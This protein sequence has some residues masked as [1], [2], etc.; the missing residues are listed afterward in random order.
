[1]LVF[2]VLYF[3]KLRGVARKFLRFVEAKICNISVDSIFSGTILAVATQSVRKISVAALFPELTLPFSAPSKDFIFLC[4]KEG[5]RKR[6][7]EKKRF[8]IITAK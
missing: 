2:E 4:K 1:M 5:A 7:K 8:T 3:A 6:R